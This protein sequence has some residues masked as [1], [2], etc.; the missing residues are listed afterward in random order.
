MID[1]KTLPAGDLL[2][3]KVLAKRYGVVAR[4][5]RRAIERETLPA[6]RL[7]GH[8]W[9]TTDAAF[10]E[11]LKSGEN[12]AGRVPKI[13]NPDPEYSDGIPSFLLLDQE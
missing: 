10:R 11:W 5:V 4:T 2:P 6:T 7:G 12:R 13:A 3:S 1:I 8:Q 9:Y